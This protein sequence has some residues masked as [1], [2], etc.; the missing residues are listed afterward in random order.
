M[1]TTFN[2]GDD[3]IDSRDIISRHGELQDEYDSLVEAWEEATK[4]L[5]NYLLEAD[6]ELTEDNTHFEKLC[7]DFRGVVSDA[8]INLD[9]FDKEELDILSEVILVGEQ[10]P[11]WSYGETLILDAHFQDYTEELINDGWEMPKEFDSNS[12]PWRYM[13]IDF[14]LAADE[15]KSDY[16]SID[17]QNEEYWI[18][19]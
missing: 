2:W 15:L 19:A 5:D 4:D 10:S 8:K 13:K 12:W 14:E 11:D 18:R 6:N 16:I 1:K 7:A 17:V 3:I 9:L